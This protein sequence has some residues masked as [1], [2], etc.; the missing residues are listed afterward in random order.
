MTAKEKAKVGS[1]KHAKYLMD[2]AITVGNET[3]GEELSH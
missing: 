2:T 1:G 3:H